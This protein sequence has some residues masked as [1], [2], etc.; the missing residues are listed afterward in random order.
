MKAFPIVYRVPVRL[1]RLLSAFAF[2]AAAVPA[3]AQGGVSVLGRSIL[4][5]TVIDDADDRP[6][7][8]ATVAIE[9]LRL[10]VVTDSTSISAICLGIQWRGA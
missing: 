9:T 6:I 10:S 7:A 3:S 1:T 2:L 4:R 5:G 8:G